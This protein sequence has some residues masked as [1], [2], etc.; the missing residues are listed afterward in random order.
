MQPTTFEMPTEEEY[1]EGDTA[2]AATF[3]ASRARTFGACGGGGRAADAFATTYNGALTSEYE[4]AK[5]DAEQT[6]LQ[7]VIKQIEERLQQKAAELD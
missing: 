1:G 7:N 4:S 3:T 2:K 5:R 6:L